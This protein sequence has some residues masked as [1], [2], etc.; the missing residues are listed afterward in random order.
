MYIR[1]SCGIRSI[2]MLDYASSPRYRLYVLAFILGLISVLMSYS[3]HLLAGR[4]ILRC[5]SKKSCIVLK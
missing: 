5:F 2:L 4:G 3:L 1:Y